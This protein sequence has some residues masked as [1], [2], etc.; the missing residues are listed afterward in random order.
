MDHDNYDDDAKAI[1]NWHDI[2]DGSNFTSRLSSSEEDIEPLNV[3][4]KKPVKKRIFTAPDNRPKINLETLNNKLDLILRRV[5]M[6]EEKVDLVS[7]DMTAYSSIINKGLA[8]MSNVDTHTNDHKVSVMEE[9]KVVEVNESEAKVGAEVEEAEVKEAEVKEAEVEEA[10]VEEAEDEIAVES[11]GEAKVEEAEN[12]V[13][14]VK[15]EKVA[16]DITSIGN[17]R[18]ETDVST[19][20]EVEDT[21]SF[22]PFY[23][24]ENYACED[25]YT[26]LTGNNIDTKIM[27][28]GDSDKIVL[29]PFASK[30]LNK[31]YQYWAYPLEINT[32]EGVNLGTSYFNLILDK[33]GLYVMIPETNY[34]ET[35]DNEKIDF[36]FIDRPFYLKYHGILV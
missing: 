10:K 32:S 15:D 5:S 33:N 6:I 21:T 24:K 28:L 3:S 17:K 26:V 9:A 31:E 4:V 35:N 29:Y 30:I 7:S 27:I 11:E 8:I 36:S 2:F 13:E 23:N 18:I 1:Q 12:E 22:V 19:V 14:E 16:E 34:Y 20:K 25:N